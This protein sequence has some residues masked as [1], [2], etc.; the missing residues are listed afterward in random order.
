[1]LERG[2]DK[3]GNGTLDS[4]EVTGSAYVCNVPGRLISTSVEPAGSDCQAG[5]VKV[6][7]GTDLNGDGVLSANEATETHYLCSPPASSVTGSTGP[8]GPVGA[9][10]ATGAVGETG[11]TGA[12]G[13]TG[14]TGPT[15][16]SG[17]A[18]VPFTSGAPIRMTTIDGGMSAVCAVLGFGGSASVTPPID[19]TGGSGEALN[20][21]ISMPTNGSITSIIAYFSTR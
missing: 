18:I 9:T 15:G 4:N 12:V 14:A 10:G 21:A 17:L 2:I 8:V 6:E 5:G 7:S 19:L 13:K 16:S 1:M 20:Y 3:N 11:A